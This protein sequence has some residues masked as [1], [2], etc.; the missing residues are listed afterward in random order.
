LL[1]IRWQRTLV[2]CMTTADTVVDDA[3]LLESMLRDLREADPLFQ[4]TNYWKTYEREIL[5]Y[6]RREGIAGFRGRRGYGAERVLG[7]FGALDPLP[8]PLA[9]RRLDQLRLFDAPVLRRLVTPR[10]RARLQSAWEHGIARGLLR[11]THSLDEWRALCFAYAR[12]A[13][14]RAGAVPLDGLRVSMAGEPADRFAIGDGLY[15]FLTLYYYLRYAFVAKH[16]DL[17]GARTVVEL[18]SGSGKQAELL[19]RLHPESTLYLFDIPPQLYVAHQFLAA[20]LPGRAVPYH[21]TRKLDRL[22]PRVPGRIYLLGSWQLPLIASER[23]DLFWSCATFGEMEPHVVANY[24]KSVDAS[25]QA[26]YLMQRM[27]GKKLAKRE[28]LRG[29]LER[30]TLRHYEHGLPRFELVERAQARSADALPLPY[31][32][33]SFW[34]RRAETS[35]ASQAAR[36]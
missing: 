36:A 9:F 26:V 24:L 1:T 35:R 3:E 19:A 15:T 2:P 21:E 12:E 32:E 33:D 6:L 22:P 16:L 23:I 5:P 7:S 20:A 31:Y 25:A 34:R 27:K 28:G 17:R 29:V 18:G 13:G 10:A 30:T 11:Q 4:P 14:Q 8:R